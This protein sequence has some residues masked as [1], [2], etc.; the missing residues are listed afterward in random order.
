MGRREGE[1]DSLFPT[2]RYFPRLRCCAE[3]GLPSDIKVEGK[4]YQKRRVTLQL[5]ATCSRIHAYLCAFIYSVFP[6]QNQIGQG[7]LQFLEHTIYT[8]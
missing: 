2:M 8:V 7:V 4:H 1:G 3:W 6:V 5:N